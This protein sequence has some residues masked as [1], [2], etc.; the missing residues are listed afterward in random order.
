MTLS[1]DRNYQNHAR[2]SADLLTDT[3]QTEASHYPCGLRAHCAQLAADAHTD[4][5]PDVQH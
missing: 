4:L 3:R 1:R 5:L 2:T